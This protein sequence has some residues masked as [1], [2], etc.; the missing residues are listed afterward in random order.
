MALLEVKKTPDG[1]ILARRKDRLPLTA[2]DREEARRLAVIEELPPRAWVVEEI[3]DRETLRAVKLC[4]AVLEDHLWL[5]LDRSFEPR[6]GL[7]IYYPEE[8]PILRTKPTQ[9]LRGIHKVKTG[10]PWLP[11]GSGRGGDRP[12]RVMTEEYLTIAEVA[13]R[14]KLKPKTVKNKMAAGIFKRGVHYFSPAGLGPRFKWSAVVAW[15][16]QTEEPTT[17]SDDASIPMPRSYRLKE[18]CSKKLD[19]AP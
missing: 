2:A 6:D 15:L 3:R 13:E 12:L 7:A 18:V 16:E 17:E 5:I 14:L 9:E 1:R 8:L 11:S 10:V 4:S 19:I